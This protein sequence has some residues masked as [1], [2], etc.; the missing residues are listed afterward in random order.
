MVRPGA[1]KSE[2]TLVRSYGNVDFANAYYSGYEPLVPQEVAECVMFVVTRPTNVVV[3]EIEILPN[4]Q[5]DPQ[6]LVIENRE[7]YLKT[8]AEKYQKQ[9]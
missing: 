5:A 1:V 3:S 9:K 6:S 4:A 8:L 7:E 2:F